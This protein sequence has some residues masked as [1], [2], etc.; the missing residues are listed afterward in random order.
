MLCNCPYI[1]THGSSGRRRK[2]HNSLIVYTWNHAQVFLGE[3]KKSIK[4]KK[5][6]KEKTPRAGRMRIFPYKNRPVLICFKQVS[7]LVFSS[8]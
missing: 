2:R 3:K 4:D 7:L 6:E 5:E 1:K 8:Y